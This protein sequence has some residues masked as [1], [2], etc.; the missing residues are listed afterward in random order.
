M[1]PEDRVGTVAAQT[2]SGDSILIDPGIYYEHIPL[3]GKALTFVGPAGASATILDGS[4]PLPDREGAIVYTLTGA[5]ADLVLEGLTIR[6]GSGA[7]WAYPG[8]DPICGGAICWW[9]TGSDFLGSL[10]IVD[11]IFQ[12]NTT[13]G[14]DNYWAVGG[15]A[16]FASMLDVV[17]LDG[18]SFSGNGTLGYGNDLYLA[19]QRTDATQCDFR[20]NQA[21]LST[22]DIHNALGT[23]TI[24]ECLF[25]AE[26]HYDWGSS[27]ESEG[28][29]VAILHSRFI[30]R[31][32]AHATK[33][34]LSCVCVDPGPLQELLL[35][36][37]LF[38]NTTGPDTAAPVSLWVYM[39]RGT[40]TV[41]ENT[42]VRVGIRLQNAGGSPMVFENNIIARGAAAFYITA[43]GDYSC[44][45]F[46]LGTVVDGYGNLTSSENLA[47]NPFFCDEAN[48]DFTLSEG[49]PCAPSGDCDLMG[50]E[51]VAC[52]LGIH[53]CCVGQECV[54]ATE[55]ECSNLGGH[56]MIDPPLTSCE[57]D[58][59]LTPAR[60]TTWGGLKALF[61]ER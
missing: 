41:R 55:E 12:D 38:W 8:D 28:G 37:N 36:G 21:G 25:D 48:G 35:S 1:Q 29:D 17:T 47:T 49:S 3:E 54:L 46:W 19:A 9:A 34:T 26:A 14:P 60:R 10:S 61:R 58:P 59:C 56:W 6:A 44:N 53:A 50:A 5:P 39:P 23:L 13:G 18:C 42:L 43:G 20:T 11:C 22:A 2:A 40:F 32:P 31:G 16:I 4:R 45:D 30:D 15:G 57:P 24:Q 52:D 51:P 27:I 33:V 7:R